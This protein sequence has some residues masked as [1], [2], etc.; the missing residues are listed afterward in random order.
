MAGVSVGEGIV[1][2]KWLGDDVRAGGTG[3]L[4]AGHGG[5][6]KHNR[7]RLGLNFETRQCRLAD[8][9]SP[10]LRARAAGRRD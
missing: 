2:K 3:W 8:G 10:S 9:R 4:V 7:V 6:G 1:M 5:R